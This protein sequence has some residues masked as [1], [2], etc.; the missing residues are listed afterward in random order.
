VGEESELVEGIQLSMDSSISAHRQ[1]IVHYQ[2]CCRSF[3]SFSLQIP[4]I[5]V[6]VLWPWL[7]PSSSH[8]PWAVGGRSLFLTVGVLGV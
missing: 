7:S 1:T 8:D 5:N 6:S 4:P 3:F 2:A